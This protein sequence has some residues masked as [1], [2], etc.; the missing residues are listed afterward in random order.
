MFN[1]ILTK[2]KILSYIKKGK[3][4]IEPYN[5][6]NV[7]VGSIDLTLSNKFRKFRSSKKIYDV[8]DDSD[9]KKVTD[10]ITAKSIVIRP[11]DTILG[12]TEEKITL[13]P[14]LCGWLEGRTRFARLGLMIHISASFM[15]PGV[16][17]RQVLEISNMGHMPYRLHAG[18]KVCQFIFQKTAGKAKYAGKFATQTEP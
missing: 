18:T 10:L 4:I 14:D 1:I 11:G 2:P 15:Q 3:I 9:Y 12:I 16:E 7:G 6:E 8:T 5:P 17:N 13:A